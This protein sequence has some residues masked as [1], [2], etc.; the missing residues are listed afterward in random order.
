MIITNDPGKSG[1]FALKELDGKETCYPT[2]DT[3]QGIIDLID[4]FHEKKQ[5]EEMVIFY[6]EQ[7]SGYVGKRKKK[8]T[9]ICCHCQKEVEYEIEEADPASRMFNFGENTGAVKMAV[10]SRFRVKPKMVTPQ[11]WQRTLGLSRSKG[12]SKYVWKH[13]LHIAAKNMYPFL[14]PT[15]KTCDALLI[16]KAAE[17]TENNLFAQIAE[18]DGLPF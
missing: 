12:M 9:L 16:L 7:N 3:E 4:R 11:A 14:K 13:T 10:M 5:P 18:G 15:L 17:M 2:P 8:K 6:M 1:G